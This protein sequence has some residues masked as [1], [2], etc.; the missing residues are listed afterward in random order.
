MVRTMTINLGDE[1]HHYVKSGD[2][3]TQSEVIREAQRML[4]EKQAESDL[5]VFQE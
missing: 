1:L 4:R 5:T 3:R 2:Y